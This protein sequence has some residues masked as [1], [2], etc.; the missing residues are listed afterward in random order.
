MGGRS[1]AQGDPC[2]LPSEIR[3][4]SEHL[5]MCSP[6]LDVLTQRGATWRDTSSLEGSPGVWGYS[7]LPA[8]LHT[9]RC[10]VGR[11]LWGGSKAAPSSAQLSAREKQTGFQQVLS[12]PSLPE[13]LPAAG[14]GVFLARLLSAVGCGRQ[15]S[16]TPGGLCSGVGRQGSPESLCPSNNL[17]RALDERGLHL[18]LSNPQ[19][20]QSVS[21]PRRVEE[22]N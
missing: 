20:L 4:D 7:S 21:E 5:Q 13:P 12:L 1:L 19:L 18:S 15:R 2:P 10:L 16:P 11:A 14:G 3:S 22:P 17:A 8:A 9:R 6:A